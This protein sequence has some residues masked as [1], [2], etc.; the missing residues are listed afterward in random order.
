VDDDTSLDATRHALMEFVFLNELT[1]TVLLPVELE[2]IVDLMVQ[3]VGQRVV[4]TEASEHSGPVVELEGHIVDGGVGILLLD[5]L[6]ECSKQVTKEG[7]TT[8]HDHH[9]ED[10]LQLRDGVHIS[11]TNGGE[12]G[13]HEVHHRDQF[14]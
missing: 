2:V 12:S 13:H 10:H 3:R 6:A 5:D 7:S 11:I 8:E 14:A 9:A 4:V 1:G